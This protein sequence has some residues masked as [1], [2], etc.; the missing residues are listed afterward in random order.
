MEVNI[1]KLGTGNSHLVICDILTA[2]YESFI[3][4]A[5]KLKRQVQMLILLIPEL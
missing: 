3:S 4:F 2:I 1:I 5:L